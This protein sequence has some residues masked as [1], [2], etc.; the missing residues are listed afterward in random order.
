MKGN[1][2]AV[3]RFDFAG[4]EIT[5][6]MASDTAAQITDRMAEGMESTAHWL[7]DADLEGMIMRFE[8]VV[9]THPFRALFVAVGVGYLLGRGLRD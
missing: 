9:R 4:T 1:D 6:S 3:E 7:R 8:R 2:R 5:S